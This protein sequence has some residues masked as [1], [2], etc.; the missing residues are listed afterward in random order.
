M[1]LIK[2][3]KSLWGFLLF[4]LAARSVLIA[5]LAYLNLVLVE[6]LADLASPFGVVM[7]FAYFN[8]PFF[9]NL[10]FLFD[11]CFSICLSLGLSLLLSAS[12]RPKH[13]RSSAVG[14]PFHFLNFNR[15]NYKLRC[16]T[17]CDTSR[18]DSTIFVFLLIRCFD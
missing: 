10:L 4:G 9:R 13:L 8:S 11:L 2:I 6:L 14:L 17:L 7:C 18:V 15:F 12:L 16:S 1:T 3:H 5:S